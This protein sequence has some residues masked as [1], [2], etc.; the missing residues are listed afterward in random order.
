M[1]NQTEVEERKHLK[2]VMEKLTQVLE[3]LDTKVSS[4]YRQVR[5]AKQY[6]WENIAQLDAAERAANRVDVSLM[7]DKGERAIAERRKIQKLMQSPY[8]GRIDFLD[9]EGTATYYIGVHSFGEHDGLALLIYDWR[10]PVASLF[11]DFE[12]G[13][14]CYTA[15]MGKVTGVI[16]L[17]RQYKVVEGNLEYMLDTSVNI[18][19]ELLQKEL[20]TTSNEKMKHIVATIQKEQNVVIRDEGSDELI[21]QGAAGSGKTSIALHRVAFL[22]YRFKETLSSRNVLILSPNRVFSDYISNVLPELGEERILESTVEEL[23]SQELAGVCRFETFSEQVA[24]LIESA[25][26]RLIERIQWKASV[27]LVQRLDSFI[28]RAD[29]RY[30]TPADLTVDGVEFSKE[31]A[32]NVYQANRRLPIKSRLDKVAAILWHGAR[33]ENGEKLP[34]SALKTMK[35]A[36]GSMFAFQNVAQ[37]YE[38]FY[39]DL[40]MSHLFQWMKGAD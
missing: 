27:Q 5:K 31:D 10:S 15:P 18:Q 11:Y 19:D 24:A 20:S 25:D 22:L 33:D 21:I 7:I 38:A 34:T 3:Q 2:F 17:K 35:A 14:A 37:M 36:I 28:A 32:W 12:L 1:I 13:E 29:D 8:F 4:S 26:E 16:Q 9:D 30:F 40:G 39:R 23:A 6:V